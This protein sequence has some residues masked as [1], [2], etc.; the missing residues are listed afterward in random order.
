[1][2]WPHLSSWEPPKLLW[3]TVYRRDDRSKQDVPLQCRRLVV[4]PLRRSSPI[5]EVSYFV[6]YEVV[7]FVSLSPLWTVLLSR[8]DAEDDNILWG[9][10]FDKLVEKGYQHLNSRGLPAARVE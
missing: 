2:V 10:F 5:S 1:M 4:M 8:R 9:R 3:N 6:V 7:R